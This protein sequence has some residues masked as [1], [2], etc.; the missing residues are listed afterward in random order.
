MSAMTYEGDANR[1][2]L[3]S[4]VRLLVFLILRVERDLIPDR[5]DESLRRG[6]GAIVQERGHG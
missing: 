3:L 1:T 2:A 4:Q 5:W 6:V